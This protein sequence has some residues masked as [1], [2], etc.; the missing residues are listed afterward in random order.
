MELRRRGYL[1]EESEGLKREGEGER[2]E[3]VIV[4]IANEVSM[5]L[6]DVDGGGERSLI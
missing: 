6:N 3:D 5:V 2:E 1:A 4:R